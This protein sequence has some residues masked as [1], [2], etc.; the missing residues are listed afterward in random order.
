M[1]FIYLF[2]QPVRHSLCSQGPYNL[3]EKPESSANFITYDLEM[4]A[5]WNF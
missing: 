5:F 4:T 1:H 2:I 3:V